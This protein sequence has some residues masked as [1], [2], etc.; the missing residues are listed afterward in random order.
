M[1]FMK[2]RSIGSFVAENYRTASVFQKYGIDFCCKGGISIEEVS[3]SNNLDADQLLSE[4][5]DA[6][7]KES[8]DSIDFRSWSLDLLVDYIE[9]KHHKYVE[10]TV[11]A[12]KQYLDKIQ[13]VHSERHPELNTIRNEFHAAAENLSSH[14][15]KEEVM[16]FPYIRKLVSS[17]NSEKIDLGIWTV[18]NPIKVMMIEHETEGERFR[19]ISRLTNDYSVPEDACRTYQVSFALLKE[20][21]SDLHLHIH[22]ENNILFPKAIELEERMTKV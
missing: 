12:L 19:L 15:K 17:Q 5:R 22:L 10:R 1:E 8:S 2:S 3:K 18:R 13:E 11:P 20:F 9:K 21:E 16:L 4:I 7:T 6:I 14:M